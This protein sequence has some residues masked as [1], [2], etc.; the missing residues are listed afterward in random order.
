M[1]VISRSACWAS[2]FA[3]DIGARLAGGEKLASVLNRVA[4]YTDVGGVVLV[5]GST[6]VVGGEMVLRSVNGS[7][8]G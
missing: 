4:D 2:A 3:S 6:V 5:A 7:S 1:T 8:A